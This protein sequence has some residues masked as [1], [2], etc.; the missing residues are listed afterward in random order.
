[1]NEQYLSKEILKMSVH[2]KHQQRWMADRIMVMPIGEIAFR[3]KI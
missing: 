2:I 3:I 1:M